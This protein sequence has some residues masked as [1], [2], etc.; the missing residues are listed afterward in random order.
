MN[1]E[2]LNQFLEVC[3]SFELNGKSIMM[4][5]LFLGLYVI[6]SSY[7]LLPLPL[8]SLLHLFFCHF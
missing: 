5:K 1:Y 2:V 7:T 6:F 8:N 3:L 4:S